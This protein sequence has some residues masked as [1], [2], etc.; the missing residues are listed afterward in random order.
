MDYGTLRQRFTAAHDYA[1]SRGFGTGY[2][3]GHQLGYQEGLRVGTI[4][5]RPD[6][7]EWRDL[8]ASEIGN[9]ADD[10][11][12]AR[13]SRT[14]D[15]AA[16]N[17]FETGFP[18]F[19]QAD[20]GAGTVYGTMLVRLGRAEWRDVPAAEIGN[21]DPDDVVARFAAIN[22]YAVRSGFMGG[23]PNGHSAVYDGNVVYGAFLLRGD[24]A[25]WRDLGGPIYGENGSH[26]EPDFVLLH[27]GIPGMDG[28]V[29]VRLGADGTIVFRGHVH[30][31]RVEAIAFRIRVLVRTGD[32][33]IVL[34]YE[35]GA[36]GFASGDPRDEDW[37]QVDSNPMVAFIFAELARAGLEV[38]A[39]VEGAITG[40]LEDAAVAVGRWVVGTVLVTFTPIL[41]IG[42]GV[43]IGSAIMTGS[44]SG[45]AR[46]VGGTL[47]LAG[48]Y[49]TMM[50]LASEGVASLGSRE[51]QI[52][53]T[54]YDWAN[55][56]VFGGR[57]P[58]R[59]RIVTTDTAGGG[60]RAF[61]YPRFDGRITVNLGADYD[62]PLANE[63]LFA[64]EL[65]HAWQL[66]NTMSDVDFIGGGIGARVC[67][68]FG[69]DP[70]HLPTGT[71]P[72]G[73]LGI[74]QQANVVEVW[75]RQ[76]LKD[77]P[78]HFYNRYI[79]ENIQTGMV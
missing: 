65:T 77:R 48:P 61:V 40:F 49:G 14:N 78:K 23:F 57:L 15:W 47:W 4:L 29:G 46:L 56:T 35:G 1:R 34:F 51:R 68:L 24:A 7:V 22:D 5:L 27:A 76:P 55:G 30:N 16:A 13:F 43:V 67:E 59:E 64:H 70:Y 72:F 19:H 2:P 38:S 17:G 32:K 75:V 37:E 63:G 8:P 60:G 20:Y 18:N 25:E 26:V 39:D 53:D 52:S 79:I 31:A 73:S 45:G 21:P 58:Q 44:P 69:T 11:V 54:E 12:W 42:V 3:N 28:W 66:G 74:E 62:D 50:A 41:L 9:P 36:G 33:A 10:D 71:P 6:A